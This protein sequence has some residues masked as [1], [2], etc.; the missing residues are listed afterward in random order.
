M[1]ISLDKPGFGVMTTD[2]EVHRSDPPRSSGSSTTSSGESTRRSCSK[3][4]GRMSSFSL[5]KHLFCMKCRGSECTLDTRC[6]ECISW[7]E[8]EMIRYVKLRK[9][10]SS[11]SK[12][13]KSSPPR[14]IPLNV[15]QTNLINRS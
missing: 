1:D 13:S 4:H 8:E 11:K 14:S 2:A 6:N 10:L 7:T 15:T 12:R 5:D 3:C 9:S